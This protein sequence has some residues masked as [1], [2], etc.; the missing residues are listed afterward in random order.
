MEQDKPGIVI[1][2]PRFYPILGGGENQ[3]RLA[4][5]MLSKN[6]YK[7]TVIASK[8]QGAPYFE[9]KNFFSIIRLPSFNFKKKDGMPAVL[10]NLFFVALANVALLTRLYTFKVVMFFFGLDYFSLIALPLKLL[11][12]KT[13]VRTASMF[14]KEIG[15][16]RFSAFSRVRL[17]LIK[18]FDIYIALSKELYFSFVA[19]GIPE[20]KIILLPNFIDEKKFFPVDEEYRL[21]L[22]QKNAL[23]PEDVVVLYVGHLNAIKGIDFLMRTINEI[24]LEEFGLKVFILG[25]GKFVSN[26][27]ENE[28]K[29]LL[30]NAG[31]KQHVN[32]VGT[33]EDVAEYYQLSDIFVLPSKTEGMPNSLLEAMACGSACIATAVGAV[34]EIISNNYNGILISYGDVKSFKNI[35]IFLAKNKIERKRLGRCARQ[36]ILH[37]YSLQKELHEYQKIFSR[38][39]KNK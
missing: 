7:V 8:V 18:A 32:F 33:V 28:I 23:K 13:L 17:I 22:R 20:N 11:G 25:S 31:K 21:I 36:T 4:A 12:K 26:S 1:I 15:N 30:R 38:L 29:D 19:D 24:D 6:G 35:L 5:T 9:R 37:N 10:E 2:S 3:A 14:S 16:I 39:A 27:M 34:P